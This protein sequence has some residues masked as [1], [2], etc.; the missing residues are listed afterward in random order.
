MPNHPGQQHLPHVGVEIGSMDARFHQ[1][2]VAV[3][4]LCAGIA[5][6]FAELIVGIDDVA[7]QVRGADNRVLIQCELL[8]GQVSQRC[9]QLALAFF[10]LAHQLTHQLGE[11]LQVVVHRESLSGLNRRHQVPRRSPERINGPGSAGQIFAQAGVL[12]GELDRTQL[13]AAGLEL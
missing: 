12:L 8:V 4:Q 11:C 1:P 3:H 5:A 2:V 10:L 9:M 13:Q 7:F 6:D